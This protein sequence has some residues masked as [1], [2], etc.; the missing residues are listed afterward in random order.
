MIGTMT[1]FC[2]GRDRAGQPTHDRTVVADLGI[3]VS[4]GLVLMPTAQQRG[5]LGAGRPKPM[6]QDLTCGICGDAVRVG[7]WPY[8]G[9][10]TRVQMAREAGLTELPLQALR[11]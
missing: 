7:K 4:A 6:K 5:D 9:L 11:K 2:V 1:I 3:D 8:R 10:W